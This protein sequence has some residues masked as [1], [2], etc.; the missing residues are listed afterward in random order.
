MGH[1][2]TV[3]EALHAPGGV[4]IYGIPEFRLPKDIVNAEVNYI[5]KLGVEVKYNIVVGKHSLLMSFLKSMMQYLLVPELD[6]H[7]G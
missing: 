6:F 4:L 3:F 7:V 1:A 2:V 5:K